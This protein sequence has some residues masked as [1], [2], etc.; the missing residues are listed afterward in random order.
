[1]QRG[2]LG[3]R[4]VARHPREN[5]WTAVNVRPCHFHHEYVHHNFDHCHNINTKGGKCF[6]GQVENVSPDGCRE[7]TRIFGD[8]GASGLS[9]ATQLPALASFIQR[10]HMDQVK[11][12][13]TV[14]WQ[15]L[16]A[17]WGNLFTAYMEVFPCSLIL[18]IPQVVLVKNVFFFQQIFSIEQEF[19][20][21]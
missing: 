12:K 8:F 14:L 16:Y 7:F 21:N 17:F 1:M 5:H 11:E 3:G 10:N 6:V 13:K 20:Q 15:T 18:L 9:W 4:G 19:L 2:G